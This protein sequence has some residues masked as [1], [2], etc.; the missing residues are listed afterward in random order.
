MKEIHSKLSIS[1]I[2]SI[3]RS[4]Y[5][6]GVPDITQCGIIEVDR[7]KISLRKNKKR[8]TFVSY[9]KEV[10]APADAKAD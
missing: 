8:V 7:D 9:L 6:M 3:A 10:F 5:Q 1:N 4:S 2:E